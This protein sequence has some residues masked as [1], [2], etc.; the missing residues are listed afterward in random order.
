MLIGLVDS[1]GIPGEMLSICAGPCKQYLSS[2]T[3][4][5]SHPGELVFRG[6]LGILD[7]VHFP[8]GTQ[9]QS[10]LLF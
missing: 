1:L 9:N 6:C 3:F 2:C 10:A 8:K 7:M 5:A 4:S